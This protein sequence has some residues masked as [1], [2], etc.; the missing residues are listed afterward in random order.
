MNDA[1]HLPMS[2]WVD[3]ARGLASPEEAT[4]VEEH[5]RQRCA[6]CMRTAKAL[7]RVVDSAAAERFASPPDDS[8]SAA[9]E[10]FSDVRLTGRTD[11]S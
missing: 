9:E 8:V 10:L 11:A 2:Q 6:P 3:W 1:D 5:L 7:L 4:A